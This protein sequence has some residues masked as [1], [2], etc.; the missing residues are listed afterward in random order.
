VVGLHHHGEFPQMS[1]GEHGTG[2]L[3]VDVLTMPRG[4][5][6]PDHSHPSQAGNDLIRDVLIESGLAEGIVDP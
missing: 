5:L 1:F 2:R 6:T 3:V 4:T